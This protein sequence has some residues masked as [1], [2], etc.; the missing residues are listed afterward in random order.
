MSSRTLFRLWA[1]S[2]DPRSAQWVRNARRHLLSAVPVQSDNTDW[3]LPSSTD[4]TSK[5][6]NASYCFEASTRDLVIRWERLKS[7]GKN[8]S[9]PSGL[10]RK[11]SSPRREWGRL[12]GEATAQRNLHF[13]EVDWMIIY[14][15]FVIRQDWL[16]HKGL[17]LMLSRVLEYLISSFN[18]IPTIDFPSKVSFHDTRLGFLHIRG[19]IHS[20]K[21]TDIHHL[22]HRE[23][24]IA[25]QVSTC[26]EMCSWRWS[27]QG[28]LQLH[29]Q[30]L[31]NL[32]QEQFGFLHW[33]VLGSWSMCLCLHRHLNIQAPS[34]T[35]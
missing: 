13:I 1:Y 33:C 9:I 2:Q 30:G 25:W 20:Y 3:S 6:R 19:P 32:S 35:I 14:N 5:P 7:K 18:E 22:H 4:L 34:A 10:L 24:W 23:D 29:T 31:R 15:A 26:L 17:S 27:L 12:R 16:I 11:Q 28:W 8:E 21:S